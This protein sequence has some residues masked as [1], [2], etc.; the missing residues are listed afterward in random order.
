MQRI[1]VIGNAGGGKSALCRKLSQALD[2]PLFPIDRMQWK[3]GW[4]AAP[5]VE[6]QAQHDLV[7]AQEAWILDGWGPW[8]LIEQ[9]F[10]AADTIIFVDH[11]LLVHYWW[12]IK[13]QLAC[14]FTPRVDGPE[15]CPMLPVTWRLLK[16]IWRIHCTLRPKL[17]A[18]I[19]RQRADKQ[20]IHIRSP[21]ELHQFITRVSSS[22]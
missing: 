8:D 21:R 10:Q 15:G 13:R 2:I 12:S 6:I 19:E 17:A 16:M 4:V 22:V 20:V 7:L 5:Y 14:I 1:A 11:P 18:L 3:P 9:R